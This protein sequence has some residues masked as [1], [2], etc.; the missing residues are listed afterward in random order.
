MRSGDKVWFVTI[1]NHEL[2]PFGHMLAGEPMSQSEAE[3]VL[4]KKD[5][6]KA[7]YHILPKSSPEPL[8]DASIT[9]IALELRFQGGVSKLPREYS[10]R[11]LQSMRALTPESAEMLRR[12]WTQ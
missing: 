12:V 4:G 6:W 8:R 3:T 2:I 5:L 9:P 11:N 7:K 10:G 1:Q